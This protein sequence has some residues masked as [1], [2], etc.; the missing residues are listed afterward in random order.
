M[1]AWN[2][3]G[4]LL[5][6]LA[7]SSAA[8]AQAQPQVIN[9]PLSRPG[10]PVELEIGIL[11]ARIEV[12]GE[13]RDDAQFEVAVASGQ[14]KIVT[15]SG[16]RTI[17]NAGY[18]FEID[19]DDN[20]ISLDTDWRADKV[21]VVARIPGRANLD[22]GTVN[23]G[24]IVV[25]NITGNLELSNTNGPITAR[26]ING[27]VIAESVNDTIDLEFTRIDEVNVTS[28]ES[29]NGDLILRLPADAG[30]DLHLDTARGEITSDFEVDVQ[31]SQGKV[32]RTEGRGG[33]SVRIENVIIARINGGGPVVRMKTMQG[34][35]QIRRT[36]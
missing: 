20:E 13:S 21:T 22:L 7:A 35:I 26:K 3:P 31:P 6:L 34:D 8:L 5:A 9:V 29:I 23:D 12:I 10:D 1:N 25:S 17:S 11:S 36:E 15:P 19:E 33:V 32:E 28:L 24:E 16:T 18:S 27:S 30:A 4:L 14:R 2:T